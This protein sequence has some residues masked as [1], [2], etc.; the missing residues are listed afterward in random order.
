MLIS[1]SSLL[2]LTL[3]GL[4]QSNSLEP[5]SDILPPTYPNRLNLQVEVNL[6]YPKTEPSTLKHNITFDKIF[7]LFFPFIPILYVIIEFGM[8]KRGD[9]QSWGEIL[10]LF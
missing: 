2:L 10:F 7:G 4:S 3:G 8:K 5:L 1:Y 6:P 9:W